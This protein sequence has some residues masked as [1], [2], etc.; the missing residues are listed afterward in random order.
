M[1]N[2]THKDNSRIIFAFVLIGIGVLWILRKLGFYIDLPNIHWENIF[3]PFRQI[4]H[5]WGHFI[6]SWQMVLIIVGLILMA[7]KRSA[8]IVLIVVGGVFILPKIFLLQGITISFL[9]P[10]VL[11]GLGVAMVARKV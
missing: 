10:V 6:F 7:G 1:D 8:G 5:G 3:Y 9:L 2:E 4:F 11:I